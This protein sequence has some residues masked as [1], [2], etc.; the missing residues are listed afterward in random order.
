MRMLPKKVLCLFGTRPEVIKFA[1]VVRQL[2]RAGSRVEAVNVASGQH[3]ELLYPMARF[4]DLRIHHDLHAMEPGQPPAMVCRRIVE[5]LL[6]VLDLEHP[7]VVMVQGD[8]STALAGSIAGSLRGIPVGHIEAGLRSGNLAAPFPEEG[9]RRTI[10]ALA[11]YHFAATRSNR[12][13]LLRE[14]VAGARVFLTGNPGVDSLLDVLHHS[15]PTAQLE[16]TLRNT[17]NQK[18]IVLTAHRRENF[19]A[20]LAAYAKALRKFVEAHQDVAVIFPRHPNPEVAAATR[21]LQGHPRIHITKAMSYADFV[22][23]MGES[24]ILV[25]DSGGIQEEAPSI[26]K[27]LLVLR[28]TTERPEAVACGVARMVGRSAD[29]LAAMLEETWRDDSWARLA[30]GGSSP[31]GRGDSGRR[32]AEAIQSILWE[33]RHADVA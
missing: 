31:F 7:S 11:A 23:L 20:P 18:R 1:P 13:T 33:E 6:P 10:S 8:T 24:W 14:G 30:R 27:P 16:Q 29:A 17:A 32:I 21:V 19:G 28:G 5:R 22:R 2:E 9:N 4:F 26:G 12:Q 25:S 15:T 3:A